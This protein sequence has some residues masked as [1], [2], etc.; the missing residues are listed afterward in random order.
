[1]CDT[2]VS[3][4]DD[5]VLFAKNSDR[6]PNEAQVLTWHAAA[7]HP[8]GTSTACTWIAIP[9]AS[10]T[11]ATVLSRPWWMWGAEMGANEHGVVIGNE[12]VF[13][14]QPH[15]DPALLGMD[16]VRLGLE[17]G[18]TAADAV[19]VMV[20]LLERHGQGGSCSQAK[21]GFT[22]HNSFLV[23]DPQGA[24][25]LE[26]A[27]SL[28]ATERVEGPGRSISNGL[29]IEGFADAH[30]NR[31]RGRVAACSLRRART[32]AAAE[33]A[34]GPLD[35]FAALRDHGAEPS[36][37]YSVVN[38]ALDAPC[39]HA[40]GRVTAT[41]TTGSW[42]ADLRGEQIHWATGTSA[43]CTSIFKPLR[44]DQPTA[45]PGDEAAGATADPAS[46]WWRHEDLHRLV[47]RDHAAS[48]ARFA[49]EQHRIEARW[50]TA[51]PATAEAFD[52]AEAAEARWRADLQAADLPDRRPRW[53]R[54]MWTGWDQRAGRASTR[55]AAA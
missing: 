24:I 22:Y 18:R 19:E 7:D 2:L 45:R 34:V 21:P 53:L 47:L 32:Q 33:V 5:G 50:V 16:L 41:Q 43:P 28:W 52:E 1:M 8:S 26:T 54:S 31:L 3:L 15:G 40:G 13:T 49:A 10:H 51:P 38:G 6:D 4:T 35:L 39:A 42:V 55:S 9:E 11:H 27:G 29:T 44:V 23:A 46:G 14:T 37:T 48:H 20:T 25:V 36:P 17:R 12:A 30:A